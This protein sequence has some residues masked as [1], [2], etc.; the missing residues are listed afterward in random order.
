MAVSI[1]YLGLARRHRVNDWYTVFWMWTYASEPGF[2]M[3]V[4]SLVLHLLDTL[5]ELTWIFFV[6]WTDGGPLRSRYG[7]WSTRL[8]QGTHRRRHP[9]RSERGREGT[10]IWSRPGQVSLKRFSLLFETPLVIDTVCLDYCVQYISGL[11]FNSSRVTLLAEFLFLAR[12][13]WAFLDRSTTVCARSFRGP[14][15][16]YFG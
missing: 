7:R 13:F 15:F 10:Q 9:R 8:D 16:I 1:V 3:Y 14:C 2:Y 5:T 6:C 11:I 12:L 4:L